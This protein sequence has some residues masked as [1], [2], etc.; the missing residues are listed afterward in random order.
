MGQLTAVEV[1]VFV[2]ASPLSALTGV[3]SKVNIKI[4]FKILY[5]PHY[6]KIL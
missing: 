1:V 4:K 5:F 3:G 2:T 6:I